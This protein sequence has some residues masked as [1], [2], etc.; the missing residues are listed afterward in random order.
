MTGEAGE[1]GSGVLCIGG[2]GSASTAEARLR[3]S[4]TDQKSEMGSGLGCGLLGSIQEGW[5]ASWCLRLSIRDD[6][7]PSNGL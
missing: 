7:V 4:A 2:S 1:E 6:P 5:E 3:A